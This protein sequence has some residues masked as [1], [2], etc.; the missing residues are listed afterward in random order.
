MKRMDGRENLWRVAGLVLV[1][2]VAAFSLSSSVLDASA[3][4]LHPVKR[5]QIHRAQADVHAVAT[6]RTWSDRQV[7]LPSSTMLLAAL[8][9]L[10]LVV[11][12]AAGRPMRS[13]ALLPVSRGP[14]SSS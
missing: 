6:R 12:G 8:A 11:V 3:S 14:P 5:D 9:F 13:V 4:S 2:I 7:H 10:G 1:T